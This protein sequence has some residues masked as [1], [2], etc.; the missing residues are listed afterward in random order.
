MNNDV[1]KMNNLCSKVYLV[2][3]MGGKEIEVPDELFTPKIIKK[4]FEVFNID[5]KLPSYLLVIL[6]ICSESNPGLV[7][8]ILMDLLEDIKNRK[9]P[10]PKGYEVS[11]D[12]FS[13]AF[14]MK[15]PII[16][17]KEIYNKYLEKFDREVKTPN[18]NLCDTPEWWLKVMEE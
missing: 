9:G 8:V 17:D 16:T 11:P 10:I 3:L 15:F 14:P 18:G 4:K 1:E 6:D 12:D 5:I 2:W 13:Y 7:Q